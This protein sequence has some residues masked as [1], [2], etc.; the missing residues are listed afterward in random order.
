MVFLPRGHSGPLKLD[1]NVPGSR[2]KGPSLTSSPGDR[3]S[4]GAGPQ[5]CQRTAQRLRNTALSKTLD[6]TY[7]GIIIGA[8]H[9][10]LI[11]GSYLAKAGLDILLVERRLT[12]CLLYTSPSPRDGL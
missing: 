1:P 7:D 11:L 4:S 6:K 10:G 5:E 2:P 12:Y 8:G 3:Q 9:H